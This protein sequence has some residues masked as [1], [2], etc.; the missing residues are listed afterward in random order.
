MSKKPAFQYGEK[1]TCP[2]CHKPGKFLRSWGD[3]SIDVLHK[4]SEKV[5]TTDKGFR[6]KMAVFED[7]CCRHGKMGSNHHTPQVTFTLAD[8][9]AA[10]PSLE[11]ATEEPF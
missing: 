3:G 11:G 9:N 4:E 7:G 6:F 8:R 10:L 1:I 5:V 2:Y